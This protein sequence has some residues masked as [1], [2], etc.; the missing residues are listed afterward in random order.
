VRLLFT[1]PRSGR[2]VKGKCVATTRKN[3]HRRTCKRT[4]KR[5]ALRFSGHSGKNEVV[6]Q[7][8]LS[9]KKRLKP[10]RC[11]LVITATNSSGHRSNPK[12]LRFRIAR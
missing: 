11:T 10:G 3:R 6:F 5:G 9:R 8:R 12:R 1:I 2:R 7:G 4:V